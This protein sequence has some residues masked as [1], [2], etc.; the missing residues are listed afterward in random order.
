MISEITLLKDSEWSA[1]DSEACKVVR[2]TPFASVK[3]GKITH[4][5]TSTPYASVTLNCYKI[6]GTI[7]GFITHKIDFLHLWTA[8]K[9]RTV[10]KDEEVIIFWT[11]KH[12]KFKPLK[13]LP[14]FP[15]LWVMICQKG[16]YKLMTD[17]KY[18]PELT[19]EARWLAE[20]PIV[21][22]KPEIME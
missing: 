1:I 4:S 18:K 2:F 3:D 20:R 8:F 21:E 10:K 15:K 11:K 22:W 6:Q 14:S 7:E 9:E 17:P 16:A 13:I 12:Y 19:G 5:D